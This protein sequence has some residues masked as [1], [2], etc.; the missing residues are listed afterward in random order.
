MTQRVKRTP[1][2]F[3]THLYA[4]LQSVYMEQCRD[5]VKRKGRKSFDFETR[6]LLQQKFEEQI[7]SV[8]ALIAQNLCGRRIYSPAFGVVEFVVL[9][10]I[11]QGLQLGRFQSI[12]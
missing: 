1:Q 6:R 5:I 7:K 3:E 4:W 10:Q 12:F 2:P 8:I 9:G 11:C